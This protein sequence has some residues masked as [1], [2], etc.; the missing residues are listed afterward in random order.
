MD[1]IKKTIN[2]Y[3]DTFGEIYILYIKRLSQILGTALLDQVVKVT[4]YSSIIQLDLTMPRVQSGQYL[5]KV[6]EQEE[7]LL[8]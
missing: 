1:P 3:P 7:V 4:S 8:E 6:G 5:R 2:N